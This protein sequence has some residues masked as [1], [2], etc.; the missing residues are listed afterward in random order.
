MLK[1]IYTAHYHR[2]SRPLANLKG[3]GTGFLGRALTRLLKSRGHEVTVVSRQ[4]GEGRITWADLSANGLPS[5]DAAVNLAGENILNPLR[6]WNED[7]KNDVVSSRLETTRSIAKA[8]SEAETPPR[9]WVL[10]TGV[11][12]Y[13]PSLTAE[14]TEESPGGDFDFLSRLVKDW[15]AVARLPGNVACQT[16]QVVV[17]SGVILG[18]DGGAISQMIW[19]FRFGLGGPIGSG[20]QYFPWIHVVDSAGIIAHTLE[21]EDVHGVLN[22]V[23]PGM[24][25]NAE[26]TQWFAS[27]LWRPAFLPLP[28]FAVNVVFGEERGVML[29]EGQKVIPQR[30]LASGYKFAFTDLSSAL[31]DI[32]S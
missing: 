30:T 12:Y 5:C 6:R 20:H 28:G 11:G 16:R 1:D 13:P 3:G 4:P 29:L 7:F 27:A 25:T 10:V 24:A 22:G 23:A 8:I 26:F 17:R 31:K 18:S 2:W 32:V 9:V 21:N 15:E 14:Y 19:P